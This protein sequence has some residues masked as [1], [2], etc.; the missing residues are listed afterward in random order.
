MP[1]PTVI[2]C[3]SCARLN[4]VPESRLTSGPS[5]GACKTALPT[6]GEPIHVSDEGLARLIRSSPVPVLVDFYADWCGPC[7]M[8]SPHLEKLGAA[9][10]GRVIIAKVDTEKFQRHAG[11]LG[12]Q[13][14]PALFLFSGGTVVDKAAGFRPFPQLQTW[15][16]PHLP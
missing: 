11:Q 3:P 7:K 4:R 6:Q 12:V 1:D 2:A 5:C 14:I 8:L 16:S 9:E 10:R 13:G 15:V